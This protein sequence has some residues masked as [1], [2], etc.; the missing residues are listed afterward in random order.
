M[1]L[2]T[3]AQLRKIHVLAKE[4]GMDSDL[5]HLYVQNMIGKEHLKDL[6]IREAIQ[7]IDALEGKTSGSGA[8]SADAA[9]DKQKWMLTKL[10][11]ELGW[12]GED[13]TVDMYRLNRFLQARFQ[14]QH[15]RF[16]SRRK[17]GMAIKALKKMLERTM[18]PC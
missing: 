7:V 15:V 14:V 12:V 16:L 9:T 13:G 18:Q 1:N 2:I 5:L 8:A 11:E 4:R 6:S 3:N 10:A 17:A